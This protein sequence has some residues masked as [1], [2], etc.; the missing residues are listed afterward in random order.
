[1]GDLPVE[2]VALIGGGVL[3]LIGFVFMVAKYVSL[4]KIGAELGFDGFLQMYADQIMEL[5][6]D[7]ARVITESNPNSFYD[8]EDFV[9]SVIEK[10]LDE[11][12]TNAKEIG[13]DLKYLKLIGTDKLAEIIRSIIYKNPMDIS[14]I[15]HPRDDAAANDEINEPVSE[16]E[17][18][19]P[20]DSTMVDISG[21]LD[22]D[23]NNV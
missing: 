10:V 18:T 15:L 13:I 17:N 21:S 19:W 22:D 8:E 2:A 4:K 14:D 11:I 20:T 16:D 12:S 7:A 9:E 23:T 5:C 1:M 6:K 3:L